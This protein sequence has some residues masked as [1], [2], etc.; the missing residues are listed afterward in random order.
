V[1][2]IAAVRVKDGYQEIPP[3]FYP[4]VHQV[5]MLYLVRVTGL[6][7]PPA[8]AWLWP[9]PAIEPV[10]S[11]QDSVYRRCHQIDDIFIHHHPGK[12]AI[13]IPGM[14][15]GV[16]HNRFNLLRQGGKGRPRYNDTVHEVP[17][18]PPAQPVIVDGAGKPQLRG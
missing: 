2:D 12:T 1:D 5:N 16:S 8:R 6:R 7:D 9:L 3:P 13:S 4:Q 10:M 14:S 15:F 18:F 11:V 17:L